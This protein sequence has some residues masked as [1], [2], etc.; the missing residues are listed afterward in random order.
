MTTVK[1]RTRAVLA[2]VLLAGAA[3][4]GADTQASTAASEAWSEPSAYVY[5]LTST[6]G[7]RALIGTFR[8]TVRDH[9]VAGARG[10]DDS[11]RRV[12]ADLPEQVPTI[13][14]LLREL[15][16]ARGDGAEEAEAAYASDGHPER[17]TID[18]DKNATD[19]EAAYTIS[20]YR[21]AA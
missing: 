9:R 13:A 15:E 21:P 16:Q 14:G 12:V 6:E 4:C 3:A 7:E 18:W 11:A 17:I 5:T 8:I 1:A 2:A 19:D 20:D 10:L